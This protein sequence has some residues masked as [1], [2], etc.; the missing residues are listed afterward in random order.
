MG[1][2]G[3]EKDGRLR[4]EEYYPNAVE[5]TY[6]GVSGYIYHVDEIIDS[7]FELQIP[8]A[9]TSSAAVEV[10]RVEWISDAYAEILKAEETGKIAIERFGDVSGKKKEWIKKTIREEFISA[11]DHPDYQH[12]LKG[13]FSELLEM[14]DLT[15]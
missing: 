3:F 10:S 6:K 2:Y 12:F 7:G 14:E 15:I 1:P 5:Q 11:S 4:L 9:V 13:K 8:D